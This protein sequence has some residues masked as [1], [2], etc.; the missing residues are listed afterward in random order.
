MK[1]FGNRMEEI[2][3]FLFIGLEMSG[4]ENVIGSRLPRARG[5][6]QTPIYLVLN[7]VFLMLEH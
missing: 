1:T 7:L 4:S 6:I 3:I 5:R 2:S